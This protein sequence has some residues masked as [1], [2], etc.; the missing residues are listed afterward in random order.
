MDKRNQM[1]IVFDI[2]KMGQPIRTEQVKIQGMY[3]GVSC[4]GRYL[5]WL[6]EKGTGRIIGA[7]LKGDKTK[8]WIVNGKS[9]QLT[10]GVI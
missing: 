2:V 1:E 3:A 10:L 8:T 4:A 9:I 6:S 5:R 7:K